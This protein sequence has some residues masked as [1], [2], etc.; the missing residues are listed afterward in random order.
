[1][2][3]LDEFAQLG[4]LPV[5]EQTMALMRGYGIKLW[6]VFQDFA[7]AHAVYEERWPSF[8][9]NAGVVQTFAPQDVLT[10][11]ELSEAMGQTTVVPELT[12]S[13]IPVPVMLPQAL[14]RMDEGFSMILSHKTKGPISAFM[15]DPTALA[16]MKAICA[17]D[18]G[19]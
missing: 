13:Q 7:Q 6:C 2:F 16:H 11:K 12:T 4:H 10:A 17:L 3:M 19:K 18:P 1:M 14:R 9:G 15:P 8:L 5:I